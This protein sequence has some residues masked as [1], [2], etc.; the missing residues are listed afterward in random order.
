MSFSE[1]SVVN[2]II[3]VYDKSASVILMKRFSLHVIKKYNRAKDDTV[4]GKG[5]KGMFC[6]KSKESLYNKQC[7]KKGDKEANHEDG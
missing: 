5:V 4:Y 7:R 1:P 6:N 3:W 2:C